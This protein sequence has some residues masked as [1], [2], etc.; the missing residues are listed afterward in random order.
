M[1]ACC[2]LRGE[3]R[4]LH[5]LEVFDAVRHAQHT[6]LRL[7]LYRSGKG[8]GDALGNDAAPEAIRPSKSRMHQGLDVRRGEYGQREFSLML[9]PEF[10]RWKEGHAEKRKDR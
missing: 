2:I 8:C 9:A 7:S 1:W 10:M 3:I 5:L 6:A 4:R